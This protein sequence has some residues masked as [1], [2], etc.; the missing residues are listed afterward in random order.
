MIRTI[1]RHLGL[2]EANARALAAA[3]PEPHTLCFVDL[4]TRLTSTFEMRTGKWTR[5][6]PETGREIDQPS[7]GK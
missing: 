3:P 6:D 1:S 4:Q 5:F 2:L 7:R